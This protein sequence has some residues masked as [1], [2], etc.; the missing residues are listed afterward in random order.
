MAF[1]PQIPGGD[2]PSGLAYSRGA[3]EG[4]RSGQYKGQAA[5]S[6]LSGIGGAVQTA[7]AGAD[8]VVKQKIYN[9]VDGGT[10]AVQSLFGVDDAT[11]A[12]GGTINPVELNNAKNNLSRLQNAYIN[13]D[14]KPSHYFAKLNVMTKSLKARYPGYEREV[15]QTISAITGTNPANSLMSSLEQEAKAEAAARDASASKWFNYEVV[16]QEFIERS[17]PGYFNLPEDQRPSQSDVMAGVA[18]L[19]ASDSRLQSQSLQLEVDAKNGQVDEKNL[20]KAAAD[21]ASTTVEQT[22]SGGF[23]TM[24]KNY[25]EIVKTIQSMQNN[26]ANAT[27][28]ALQEMQMGTANL[29]LTV[30]SNL[31]SQLST[32]VY[33]QMPN[34]KRKEIIEAAVAPLKTLSDALNNEDYGLVQVHAA[35]VEATKN[36]N[37][38]EAVKTGKIDSGNVIQNIITIKDLT[39]PDGFPVWLASEGNLTAMQEAITL[40]T[41]SNAAMGTGETVNSD[42]DRYSSVDSAAGR[43]I[44]NSVL[45]SIP[46]VK[47]NAGMTA[48]IVGYLFGNSPETIDKFKPSQRPDVF[49]SMFGPRTMEG[50][51]D[52]KKTDP[53]A[54]AFVK[55]QAADAFAATSRPIIA[56]INEYPQAYAD[57]I[58]VTFDPNTGQLNVRP[59][60]SYLQQTSPISGM[61]GPDPVATDTALQEMIRNYQEL[62]KLL[63]TMKGVVE[64][65]GGDFAASADILLQSMGVKYRNPLSPDERDERPDLSKIELPQGDDSALSFLSFVQSIEAPAGYNQIY[66]DKAGVDELPLDQMTID[67]VIASQKTRGKERGS[68][69]TGG[70]QIMQGTLEDAKKALGLT[71]HEYFDQET[72]TAIGQWLLER[73]GLSD[74]RAGKISNEKFANNLAMEWAA[75]PLA[76]GKS[77]YSKVGKNR[78]LTDRETLMAAVEALRTPTSGDFSAEEGLTYKPPDPTAADAG[79]EK[80]SGGD[81]TDE[82]A[83]GGKKDPL[84][85]KK[86]KPNSFGNW[87]KDGRFPSRKDARKA[88]KSGEFFGKN[89][90]PFTTEE[91]ASVMTTMSAEDVMDIFNNNADSPATRAVPKDLSRAFG[92]AGLAIKKSAVA[93]LGFDPREIITHIDKNANLTAA[94]FYDPEGDRMWVDPNY[95]TTLVHE[96]IHRGLEIVRNRFEDGQIPHLSPR[97]EEYLVRRMMMKYY[98][99]TVE[100]GKGELGDAQIKNAQ[101]NY[102][103]LD[104]LIPIIEEEAA[105]QVAEESPGPK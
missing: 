66:N 25:G 105:K 58:E 54:F 33:A 55:K 100:M 12:E 82:M 21:I 22:L 88:S 84:T 94:G 2:T 85:G 53:T 18:R 78:A 69:A 80:I 17:F 16:N 62:N 45:G 81:G 63:F 13:G 39:G 87:F 104:E 83:G 75:L 10:D 5:G 11:A 19:K 29:I 77:Y 4:D 23:S 60:G 42:I 28:E 37:M 31:Q 49:Q 7:L 43:F 97:D 41:K 101:V 74:F 99:E 59:N 79:G 38:A 27:P 71:G 89:I 103:Y 51:T 40:I 35:L 61:A 67:E 47:L 48:S 68:S 44:L 72:Q 34:D 52:L 95:T 98:G 65:D 96:S 64:A 91:I 32:G 56:E 8:E 70:L 73:R 92:Q 26:P 20:F 3:G 93:T 76:S 57:L 86:V 14:I 102:Q 1:N 50:L 36:Q 15:D 6:I 30:T 9:E 90:E 24:G 46:A